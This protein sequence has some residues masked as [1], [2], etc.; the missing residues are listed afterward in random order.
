VSDTGWIVIIVLSLLLGSGLS[1]LLRDRFARRGD[2]VETLHDLEFINSLSQTVFEA[3]LAGRL[4]F[5]NPPAFEL[6]GY[7]P[8]D[9]VKGISIY[10]LVATEDHTRLRE[11]LVQLQTTSP[12]GNEYSG[13][14]KDGRRF[15]M[16]VFANLIRKHN[17]P[18]GIRGVLF[19]ISTTK[20]AIANLHQSNEW[21]RVVL[22]TA[23]VAIYD[24][25]REGRVGKLWNRGA[26]RILGWNAEEVRGKLLPS[27]PS[28]RLAEFYD[29]I[30]TMQR[31]ESIEGMD[32]HRVAKDGTPV[33]YS[34]YAAPTYDENGQI[35][36]S[37][38]VL[39]DITARKE[40][41]QALK[42]SD[43][44]FRAIINNAPVIFF[45]LDVKG[46]ITYVEG[47]GLS[48]VNKRAH[49]LIGHS[50]YR[51][52]KN[53][54]DVLESLQRGLAGEEHRIEIEF[55]DLV[56]DTWLSPQCDKEGNV[57]SI[58]G[59]ATDISS[60]RSVEKVVETSERRFRSLVQNARDMIFVL[61]RQANILYQSP[62]VEN[63]L[64]YSSAELLQTS[65]FQI[66]HPEDVTIASDAFGDVVNHTNSGIPTEFRVRKA[67]GTYIYLE[68]LANELF[69]DPAIGGMI[70]TARDMTERK[71]AESELHRLN[72]ALRTTSDCNLVLVRATEE[73]ALLRDICNVIVQVGG[74]KL[75]WVGY[76]VEGSDSPVQLV[77][78]AGDNVTYLSKLVA[79]F[80][81]GEALTNPL[82]EVS[83]THWP[84][85]YSSLPNQIDQVPLAAEAQAYGYQAVLALP[86][87]FDEENFGCLVIYADR[88]DAF[89]LNEATLLHELAHD[90]SFG[91]HTI[92][93]RVA[94][95][96][97]SQLLEQSNAELARAY[98]AT[99]EGWSHA[100]ELRERETA[101]HSRRVVD[102]T[103]AIAD[104]MGVDRGQFVH[105]RRGALLHDIGK[106]GI[107]DS[108]LLKPGPLSADE[109]VTMRQHPQYAYELLSGISYLEPAMEIP[110][111]HHERWD[112]SGYPRGLKGDDIP[113]AARIFAV[114]DVWDALTSDRPY[115]PAWP[116][117]AVRDYI[118]EHAGRMF[119][120]RV[121]D[122]FLSLD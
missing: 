118:K 45:A 13:V 65:A 39:V 64:G 53:Y 9:L 54:P 12:P 4:V 46:M 24:L 71:R 11:N 98:D 52:F 8:A 15:P 92:R 119:D 37:I 80:N 108:I 35:T 30:Q 19:D 5:A 75:A 18:A 60:R 105:L 59:V 20:A 112:G 36:G 38:S 115:R 28:D 26:E 77:A 89:D 2:Q 93:V 44:R 100:L 79:W 106:M 6:F 51:I 56:F 74:Y 67:D 90:L 55:N 58:L 78:Q 50:A 95:R 114:V 41:E 109:W 103:L 101:G 14:T 96:R 23:P 86:I 91:I 81:S 42:E 85:V 97:S 76:L 107:P 88:S 47:M 99:L 84:L 7:Q 120:P 94:S 40:A 22:E 32:V 34:V 116:G 31:G 104:R 1:W 111:A 69:D 16:M 66:I 117:Q 61:D 113:L 49:K 68:A 33:D 25:D 3:D 83:Y 48:L 102:L 43:S 62:S 10:D 121:V 27:V 82:L 73:A 110:F 57:T 29:T 87:F 122:I 70:I 72:R 21:M 17:Q 63:G